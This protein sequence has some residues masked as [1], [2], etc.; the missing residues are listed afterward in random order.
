LPP[1]PVK[2]CHLFL[3]KLASYSGERLPGAAR[4]E[5]EDVN[6]A[7]LAVFSRIIDHS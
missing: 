5:I 6:K 3:F 2:I 7:S 4:E 1:V